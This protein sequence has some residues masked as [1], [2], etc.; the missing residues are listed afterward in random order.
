M[1]RCEGTNKKPGEMSND[2]FRRNDREYGFLKHTE[3]MSLSPWESRIMTAR[4]NQLADIAYDKCAFCLFACFCGC[5]GAWASGIGLILLSIMTLQCCDIS[6]SFP[7]SFS[8]LS[9]NRFKYRHKLKVHCCFSFISF[10]FFGLSERFTWHLV[11]ARDVLRVF[12]SPETCQKNAKKYV[13]IRNI[14]TILF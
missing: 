6:L 11:E 10:F 14:T 12:R 9:V 13:L 7:P 3:T 4:K 1:Q 2:E 5:S 8:T